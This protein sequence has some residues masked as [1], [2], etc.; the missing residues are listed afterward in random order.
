M[1]YTLDQLNA[2]VD[3]VNCPSCKQKVT[4]VSLNDEPDLK[5]KE[6]KVLLAK[7]DLA[8]VPTVCCD[9]KGKH[10]ITGY[11]ESFVYGIFQKLQT[12][13]I[14]IKYHWRFG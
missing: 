11:K 13:W 2:V 4:V 8:Q 1:I 5:T 12:L 10:T 6:G 3:V 14:N 9:P 7:L